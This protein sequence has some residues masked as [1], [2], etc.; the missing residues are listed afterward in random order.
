M[1]IFFFLYI[2]NNTVPSLACFYPESPQVTESQV[3]ILAVQSAVEGIAFK[4]K[5]V[6]NYVRNPFTSQQLKASTTKDVVQHISEDKRPL[7]IRAVNSVARSQ[8]E[9][10]HGYGSLKTVTGKLVYSGD[11]RKGKNL[12]GLLAFRMTSPLA[13]YLFRFWPKFCHI[14][15]HCFI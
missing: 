7:N 6:C 11:W 15:L 10:P 4:S 14:L 3:N 5:M 2:L 8:R 9:L 12:T 1:P 13:V